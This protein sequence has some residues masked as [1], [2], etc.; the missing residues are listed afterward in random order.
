[1]RQLA[2][3]PSDTQLLT[4][5]EVKFHPVVMVP[6]L[7]PNQVLDNTDGSQ[8][9]ADNRI[10][11]G[12]IICFQTQP[13]AAAAEQAAAAAAGVTAGAAAAAVDAAGSSGDQQQPQQGQD[14]GRA[15]TVDLFLQRAEE[16]IQVSRADI[17]TDSI[18]QCG[19]LEGTHATTINQECGL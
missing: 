14:D 4:F 17:S 11:S 2:G 6:A 7:D 19:W 12:D 1:M 5:E 15:L 18:V 3:L 16:R 13:T 8:G 9:A 10:S